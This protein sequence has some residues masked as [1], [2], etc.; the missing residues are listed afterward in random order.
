MP[1]LVRDDVHIS[2]CS[3]EVGKNEGRFIIQN[4]GAIPSS[5][6]SLGRKQVH[7]LIFQHIIKEFSGFRRA[8]LIEFLTGCHDILRFP[9]RLRISA[10][11][12]DGIVRIAHRVGFPK[13]LCLSLVHLRR[14]RN[15][16]FDN[17]FPELFHIRLVIAV[18]VHAVI[19]KL[20]KV[21]VA[22]LLSHLIAQVHHLI[23]DFIQL[24]LIV[25]VPLPLRLP[26]GKTSLII[27]VVFKQCHLGKRVLLPFKRNLRTG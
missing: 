27:F 16:I 1:R 10:A 14:H 3:I 11:E 22:Q 7:Q 9:H 17:S 26:G 2:L 8:P 18:P 21:V 24:V 13:A 6:L 19:T 20:H 5:L 25:F 12:L 4:A 15:H 23:I